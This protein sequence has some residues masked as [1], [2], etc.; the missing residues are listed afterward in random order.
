MTSGFPARP[1]PVS[2]SGKEHAMLWTALERHRDLGLLIA[3]LGFGGGFLWYH[4]WPKLTAG[5]ERWAGIGNA[6]GN[7]GI[8]F[9][10]EWW[11]LAAALGESLGGLCM[12]LGLCFRP[13][14]LVLACVMVVATT[15]HITTGQGTPAHAFKNAWLFA[16]LVLVGPGRY[17]L[18]HLLTSRAER[19]RPMVV[20]VAARSRG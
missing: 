2:Y 15:N 4:G 14:A 19:T 17:S 1:E 3:R 11:G 9:A 10:P 16:G 18:D 8:A 20:E 7:L 12:L 13:A 5:W 6:M